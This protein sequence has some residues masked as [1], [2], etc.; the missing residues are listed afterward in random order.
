MKVCGKKN[1][2]AD[3]ILT[4]VNPPTDVSRKVWEMAKC[5]QSGECNFKGR[6][7]INLHY[8]QTFNGVDMADKKMEQ[9]SFEYKVT[10][11]R[12]KMTL[13]L[14]D[15]AV[16]NAHFVYNQIEH[17]T[18]VDF[19]NEIISSLEQLTPTKA[20]RGRKSKSTK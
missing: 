15:I 19:R 10:E 14:L 12:K 6:N 20:K 3:R 8:R 16:N 5:I 2:L 4:I 17:V 1:E 9:V 11:W 13:S 7:E 18:V